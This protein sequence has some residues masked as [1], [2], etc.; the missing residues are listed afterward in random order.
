MKF[1]RKA[2]GIKTGYMMRYN[3]FMV[4]SAASG[5]GT[6]ASMAFIYVQCA[7]TLN[8]LAF[9]NFKGVSN[10]PLKWSVPSRALTESTKQCSTFTNQFISLKGRHSV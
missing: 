10:R 8:V 7:G 1:R 5:S 9:L 6:V 3:A 2:A 4:Q